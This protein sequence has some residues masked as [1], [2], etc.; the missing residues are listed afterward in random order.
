MGDKVTDVEFE[1]FLPGHDRF[2]LDL[3]V[4]LAT[5]ANLGHGTL[6]H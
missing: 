4:L 1:L 5:V 2:E 3:V 6:P